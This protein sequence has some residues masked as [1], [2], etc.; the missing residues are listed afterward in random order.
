[1][2]YFVTFLLSLMILAFIFLVQLTRFNDGKMHIVFCDVGQ[3]DAIFIRTEN[4]T[5]ILIDGGPDNSILECLGDSL[6]FWD[7]ELDAI[8]LTHPHADHLTGLTHVLE[9]YQ[10]KYYLSSGV[11]GNTEIYRKL[12]DLLAENKVS[13]KDLAAGD[14]ITLGEKTSLEVLWPKRDW[15]KDWYQSGSKD[16][17]DTSLVLELSFG[18]FDILLTGDAEANILDLITLPDIEVLKVPHQGSKGALLDENLNLLL[19]ELAIIMVGKNNYGHPSGEIIELLE[20]NSVKTL[21][22]D[23]NGDVKIETDGKNWSVKK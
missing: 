1:M 19:P 20:S 3:G 11:S 15:L 6:P 9:R 12:V 23:L 17:N 13:A 22:T 7:R 16:P 5:D 2:R 21:R 14:K 18:S 10:V 4:K 8:F